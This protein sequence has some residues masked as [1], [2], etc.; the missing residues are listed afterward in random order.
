[1]PTATQENFKNLK[2]PPKVLERA[3]AIK[4]TDR[5]ITGR[6]T[7]LIDIVNIGI[8]HLEEEHRRLRSGL[9]ISANGH[10][11]TRRTE[12]RRAKARR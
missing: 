9:L 3:K 4:E 2:L 7:T 10:P 5:L 12:P 8:K 6:S 11:E 1:M